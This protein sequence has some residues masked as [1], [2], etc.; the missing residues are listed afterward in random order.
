[1]RI[2]NLRYFLVVAEELSFSAAA[3]R[4]HI[5]PSPLSRAIKELEAELGVRLLHRTRGRIRLTWAGEVF[6]EEAHRMLSFMD[7]AR[8]RVHAA[9]KGY[10]GRLRIGLTDGLAQPRLTRLLARCREEEPLTE[11]RVVEM[12]F[13][14]MV[15][16][17]G[18]DQIDAGF[19]TAHSELNGGFVKKVVWTDRP[20]IAIPRNHPLLSLEKIPLQEVARYALIFCHPERCS[21]GYNVIR[22]WFG[23][24][25]LPMPSI[26]EYVSGHELMMLLVAAG[27]GIGVAL[28]SQVTLFSHPDVI[29]RPVTDDVPS[30]ETFIT[31]LDKPH[32]EELG[33]FV[34]RAQEVGEVAIA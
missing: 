16:A 27:Y 6:R 32:S 17:L 24:Y 28:E 20:A 30:A 13:S 18:H 7:G 14:E 34:A 1:M 19:T 26:A 12:T 5:E 9:A 8:T 4:V 31:T 33:R 10:R 11:V 23:E 25:G 22:R 2:R 15:K 21:G 29:I 3:T